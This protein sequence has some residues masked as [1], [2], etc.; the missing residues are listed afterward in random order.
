MPIENIA[1]A[2]DVRAALQLVSRGATPLG[3]VYRT[4]AI[5]DRGVIVVAEFPPASH[6]PIVY[7]AALTRGA[8]DAAARVLAYLQS[9]NAQAVFVRNGFIV[10]AR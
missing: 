6:P 2:E 3:I 4:D 7:P 8:S 9:P 5:A 10:M 1:P